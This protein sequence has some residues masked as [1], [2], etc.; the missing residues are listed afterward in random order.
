M[1][2]VVRSLQHTCLISCDTLLLAVMLD[3]TCDDFA[4]AFSGAEIETAKQGKT[5]EPVNRPDKTDRA[6]APAAEG[7]QAVVAHDGKRKDKRLSS[8]EH[9]GDCTSWHALSCEQILVQLSP[10]SVTAITDTQLFALKSRR[11]S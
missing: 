6:Q 3:S 11:L 1:S 8:A 7:V 9:P 2:Y 5:S 4:C 10:M